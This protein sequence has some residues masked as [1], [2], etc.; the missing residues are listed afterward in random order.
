MLFLEY[1]LNFPL[2]QEAHIALKKNTFE[3][4]ARV[5]QICNTDKRICAARGS[6]TLQLI[7]MTRFGDIF[8][9]NNI[10]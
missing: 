3:S 4:S 10:F 9:K 6:R 2:I 7:I 1:F 5:S 8:G